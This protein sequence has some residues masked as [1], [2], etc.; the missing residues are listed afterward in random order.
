MGERDGSVPGNLFTSAM[1][2][3]QMGVSHVPDH[4]VLPPLQRHSLALNHHS[5]STLPIIDT[6]FWSRIILV[7]H[8]LSCTFLVT[9]FLYM[10]MLRIFMFLACISY[11]LNARKWMCCSLLCLVGKNCSYMQH[12]FSLLF[13]IIIQILVFLQA[14]YAH[15][16]LYYI[17][18]K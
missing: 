5:T 14:T 10:V 6:S 12:F 13:I 9:H 18:M 8:C 15:R 16:S 4:F 1:T 2:L 17:M 7:C 3:T 11:P